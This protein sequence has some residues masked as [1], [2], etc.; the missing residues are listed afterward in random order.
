MGSSAKFVIFACVAMLV[1]VGALA[2]YY[3]VVLKKTEATGP[4]KTILKYFESVAAG[5]MNAVASCF[6]AEAQPDQAVVDTLQKARSAGTF[7]YEDIK[8][9]TLSETATDA[10]VQIKDFTVKAS[11]GGQTV[12]MK[13]SEIL[14]GSM[15]ITYKLVNSNGTWLINT[16]PSST[17]S[18][19]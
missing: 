5:D 13:M 17:G 11:G 19:F 1:L 9:K 10:E 16:K 4:E 8:L 3:F 7:T 6:T 14:S 15:M 12:K 2:G 18:I